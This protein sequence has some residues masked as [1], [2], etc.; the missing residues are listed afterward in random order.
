MFG[1]IDI[2]IIV[3]ITMIGTALTCL[4]ITGATQ[5]NHEE[6]A[7]R[8]GYNKGYW[9]RT[10]P[11]TNGDKIRTMTDEELAD[12]ILR[13]DLGEAPYCDSDN[14]KCNEMADAGE[15]V[16]STMC[17]QCCIKWLQQ[18]KVERKIE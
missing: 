14:V 16:P 10:D 2:A 15:P 7:Y 3:V 5:L 13:I 9:N 11:R 6:E 8:E 1:I 4:F 12:K 17:R 18:E